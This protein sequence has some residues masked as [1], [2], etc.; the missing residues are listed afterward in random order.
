[1]PERPVDPDLQDVL[2]AREEDLLLRL[3]TALPVRVQRYDATLQVAD[4]VPLV[5][6]PVPRADGTY[7]H[8]ELPVVPSAPVVWPRVGAWA[9]TMALQPG[10]TGLLVCCQADVGTWRAGD[11]SP[12]DPVDLRRHHLSHGVFVPGLYRRGAALTSAASGTA[13]A[14]LG[15]DTS[16]ARI[17]FRA[18]GDV[19]VT[20]ATP[21]TL[22]LQGGTQPYVNGTVYAD[23]LGTF[24]AVLA[25]WVAAV[26]VAVAGVAAYAVAVALVLPVTAPAAG[27]LGPLLTPV[28]AATTNMATAITNFAA[29]RAAY[30]STRIR[31]S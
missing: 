10:D 31:G 28:V 22:L 30:L 8:E 7:T 12:V 29:A 18:G 20:T 2:D 9:L 15:H 25:A 4:V 17:V 24:L 13:S 27:I 16:G 19:E 11:G 26:G 21:G 1:M 3:S 14:V 5:R 23:A 6:S